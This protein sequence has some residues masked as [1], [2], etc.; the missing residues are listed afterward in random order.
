MKLNLQ[1]RTTFMAVNIFDRVLEKKLITRQ[2]LQ[3][4][5]I[6]TFFIASKFED[7]LPPDLA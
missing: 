2:K 4:L 7:I 5:G 3:L 1:E 6:T